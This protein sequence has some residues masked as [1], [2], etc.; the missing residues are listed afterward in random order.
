MKLF[1]NFCPGFFCFQNTSSFISCILLLQPFF[2]LQCFS[3]SP[4]AF[5]LG[6]FY[7]TSEK[8]LYWFVLFP[9]SSV[10][11]EDDLCRS[12]LLKKVW[13]TLVASWSGTGSGGDGLLNEYAF[14][15]LFF[16]R[17]FSELN[18]TEMHL[19]I[20]R[21]INLP[22]PPGMYLKGCVGFFLWVG[23]EGSGEWGF[24]TLKTTSGVETFVA[25][26]Y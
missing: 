10:I 14:L 13:Q 22:A 24:S 26:A 7:C 19:L 1:S 20:V 12:A 21:G 25:T 8:F 2:L 6:I 23:K 3:L 15:S 11:Y 5:V 9:C 18:S 4:F 17:I 16:S